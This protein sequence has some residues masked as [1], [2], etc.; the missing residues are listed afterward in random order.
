[1]E[2]ADM[3]NRQSSKNEEGRKQKEVSISYDV[4]DGKDRLP[5]VTRNSMWLYLLIISIF[6]PVGLG[7]LNMKA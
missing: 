4:A 6:N 3:F 5:S 2:K 1:V 7:N